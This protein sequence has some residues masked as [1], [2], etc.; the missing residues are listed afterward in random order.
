MIGCSGVAAAAGAAVGTVGTVGTGSG[1]SGEGAGAA[2]VAP[3][4]RR[5][6]AGCRLDSSIFGRDT[7]RR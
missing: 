4:L 5:R 3:G 1:G 2:T 6:T 7:C